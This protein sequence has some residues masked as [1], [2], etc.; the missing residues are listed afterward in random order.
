MPPKNSIKLGRG[1]M[2]VSTPEGLKP[3]GEIQ[4]VELTEESELDILGNTPRYI[5]PQSAEFTVEVTLTAEASEALRKLAATAEA[6]WSAFKRIVETI[7]DMVDNYPNRRV[8]Y[9]A[10]HG[11][12]KTRKKNVKRIVRYYKTKR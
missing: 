4:E 9:L 3:L 1:Q 12:P 11:K 7:K 10:A 6:A 5:V 2:Y 8:V